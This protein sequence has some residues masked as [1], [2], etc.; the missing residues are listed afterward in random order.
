KT[1][2]A[3]TPKKKRI[4]VKW[5]LI[6]F[7]IFCVGAGVFVVYFLYFSA[8]NDGNQEPYK[9]ITLAHIQLPEEMLKFTF[10]HFPE[11]YGVMIAANSEINIIEDEIRRIDAVSKKYPDQAKI[12]EK[13]IKTWEK[14]RDTLQKAFIKIEK[15]VKETFVLYQVNTPDGLARIQELKDPLTQDAKTALVPVIEQTQRLKS[16]EDAP[17]GFIQKNIYK[18]K[19]KFL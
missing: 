11:L 19:K 13:E 9:K 4:P 8:N 14:T 16:N 7:F 5:I 12:A 3:Q 1:Q 6:F 2:K 15:P 10:N 17:R 18:L